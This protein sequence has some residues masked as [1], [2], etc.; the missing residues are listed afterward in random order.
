MTAAAVAL[1]LV[2]SAGVVFAATPSVDTET[3]ETAVTSDVTEG[4][5]Q[6]YN[7]TTESAIAFVADSENAKIEVVQ[8]G[9]VLYEATPNPD[10]TNSTSGDSYYSVNVSDNAGD[11]TGLVAGA[12]QN[13]SLTVKVYND[14]TVDSPDVLEVNYTFV[15]G[16]VTS[17][18]RVSNALSDDGV[19]FVAADEK[20]LFSSLTSAFSDSSDDEPGET[21]IEETADTTENTS[22]VVVSV[23]GSNESDAFSESVAGLDDGG[24][25]YLS[26]VSVD[27]DRVPVFREGS[28]DEE[29][30][31]DNETY[32]TIS[33]DGQTITIWNVDGAGD[34]G[35]VE[36]T[37]VGNDR[38]GYTST[39]QVLTE[40]G[41]DQFDAFRMAS[42]A[43]DLNGDEF[44]LTED[45]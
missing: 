32:A 7:E 10:F 3:A 16:E 8:N 1:L 6:N 42:N 41:V 12:N 14:T 45:N 40:Y 36:V 29:W 39:Y 43:L 17:F 9:T 2:V 34:D 15:N 4:S 23:T 22:K 35:T 26:S 25:T 28:V 38:A 33:S 31:D 11:Y 18:D 37:A 27:G 5:D 44:E 20:G 13:A 19:E 21:K 24:V 30:L